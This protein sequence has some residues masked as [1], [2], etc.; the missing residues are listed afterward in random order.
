MLVFITRSVV[1]TPRCMP[2]RSARIGERCSVTSRAGNNAEP[3]SLSPTTE[4]SFTRVQQCW[5]IRFR[6]VEDT[7]LIRSSS[8][9]PRNFV[10][11]GF[12]KFS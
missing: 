1:T 5:K 3:F 6:L 10:G 7:H 11:G 8:G 12:N 9:V 4:S 2:T